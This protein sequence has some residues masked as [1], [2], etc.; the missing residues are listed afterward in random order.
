LKRGRMGVWNW[1]GGGGGAQWRPFC[2]SYTHLPTAWANTRC[3]PGKRESVFWESKQESA[4][5]E[6]GLPRLCEGQCEGEF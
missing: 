6:R 3:G 2:A 4:S 1:A 5:G